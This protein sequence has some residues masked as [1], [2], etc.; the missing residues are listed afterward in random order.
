MKRLWLPILVAAVAVASVGTS[1]ADEKSRTLDIYWVDTEGGGSTLLVTPVG[2]TVLIDSGNPG[3]RDSQRIKQ[4]LTEVAGRKQIDHLVTTHWHRDH[5]GGAAELAQLV[6][7]VNVHD[8][9][10]PENNPD[11]RPASAN[12]LWRQ[13]R[14]PYAEMKVAH[15]HKVRPGYHVPLAQPAF[16]GAPKLDLRVLAVDQK[17][18]TPNRN[19]LRGNPFAKDLPEDKAEDKT[20]NANSVVTLLQWG[21]F[22]FFD[23]GDLT[24]NVEKKLVHPHNVVGRVD[25]YQVNHHGLDSSNNPLLVRSLQPTVSIMNNGPTKGTSEGTMSALKNAGSIEAMYQVHENVRPDGDVNNVQNKSHIANHGKL[26]EDCK[27]H[28][29]KMSIA[30]DGKSYTV[31]VLS[32]GHSRTFVTT[33]K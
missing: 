14:K 8:K 10:L 13:L 7:I 9:G 22:R 4:V 5:F 33:R 12:A 20:D 19:Q 26:G 31:E 15:R 25:V 11:N 32:T 17:V 1:I 16:E 28:P 21:D 6:P 3:G 30:P 27:A 29:I 24:W 18:I 23:G 2:E